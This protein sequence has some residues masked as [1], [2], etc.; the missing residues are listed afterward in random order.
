[1]SGESFL[2]VCGS[3][4][5]LHRRISRIIYV[6]GNDCRLNFEFYGL[7]QVE[8]WVREPGKMAMVCKESCSGLRV[9]NL[10]SIEGTQGSLE[11][12]LRARKIVNHATARDVSDET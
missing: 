12:E 6:Y 8:R 5:S 4:R 1:M 11:F 9:E 10:L 2:I 3:C 7:E